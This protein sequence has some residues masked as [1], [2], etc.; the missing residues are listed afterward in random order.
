MFC[1]CSRPNHADQCP[2]LNP[3]VRPVD[4]TVPASLLTVLQN[5]PQ[6]FLFSGVADHLSVTMSVRAA[7]RAIRTAAPL[8]FHH[9]GYTTESMTA[10]MSVRRRPFSTNQA[11]C[12]GISS[13]L[14]ID[15]PNERRAS[16]DNESSIRDYLSVS[17]DPRLHRWAGERLEEFEV[18]RRISD[19][20]SVDA[21]QN[22]ANEIYLTGQGFTISRCTSILRIRW[23]HR[24]MSMHYVCIRIQLA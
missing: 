9:R 17:A 5:E 6:A 4:K 19:L 20:S 12:A 1:P 21:I 18:T 22:P 3:C 13:S 15:M 24:K 14:K 8:V 23:D 16:N 2:Q 11:V 10:K 7:R